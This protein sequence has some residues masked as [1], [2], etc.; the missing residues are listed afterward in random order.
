MAE[1]TENV[2]SM[3]AVLNRLDDKSIA[4]VGKWISAWNTRKK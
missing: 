4:E 1:V 3:Y 2:Q